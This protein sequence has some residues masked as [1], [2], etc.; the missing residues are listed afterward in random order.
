MLIMKV[1]VRQKKI[2]KGAITGLEG[3]LDV[4]PLSYLSERYNIGQNRTLFVYKT[5]IDKKYI[6]PLL[7]E[8]YK[9]K[10]TDV[11]YNFFF[12]NC[13]SLVG[14]VFS[15][16]LSDGEKQYSFPHLIMPGRLVHLFREYGLLIDEKTISPPLTKLLY[17][18]SY[19]SKSEILD[20]HA[21]FKVKG[22]ETTIEEGF[23]P[24][25]PTI[26]TFESKTKFSEKVG[27]LYLGM[28]N[29]KLSFGGSL[30]KNSVQEQRQSAA[31]LY[32]FIVLDTLLS[33]DSSL[34]LEKL[35]I[36]KSGKY[37]KSNLLKLTPST[38]LSVELNPNNSLID[39]NAG[40]GLS[41]GGLHSL[42]TVMPTV[43]TNIENLVLT[44]KINSMLMLYWEKFF[45]LADIDYPVY[46]KTNITDE[47]V[48][49]KLGYKF[50]EYFSVDG[51]FD[52]LSQDY[53]VYLKYNFYPLI[54]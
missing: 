2:I 51:S 34:H 47:K 30:F 27:K 45:V 33:V 41:F 46:N 3:Y 16:V 17:D 10:E 4:R 11:S 40:Y 35:T 18:E 32:D 15:S 54:I 14:D 36:F 42:L 1:L 53:N 28:D 26:D 52:F 13:S 24:F 23:S 39:L 44:L 6:P 37:P 5:N 38:S 29:L 9:F 48:E 43:E 25:I 19:L 22:A 8:F 12:Y 49:V 50:N 21:F 7:D 31:I 20:R